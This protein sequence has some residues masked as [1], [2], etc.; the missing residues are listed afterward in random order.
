MWERVFSE[1]LVIGVKSYLEIIYY[2]VQ[3]VIIEG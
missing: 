3:V 1:I 2:L